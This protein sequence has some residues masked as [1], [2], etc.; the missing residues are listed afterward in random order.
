MSGVIN[1]FGIAGG[2]AWGTAL[3]V[4]LSAKNTNTLLWARE[5]EVVDAIN[6]S[7]ENPDFLPGIP[8]DSTIRATEKLA[9]LGSVEAILLAVPT[10][11]LRK[12]IVELAP[13]ISQ[14]IPLVICSKGIETSSCKLMSE[15][16]SEIL[17]T[18]PISILS[19]PTFAA[20]VARGLPTAVTLASADDIMGA[21]LVEA[22]GSHALRPYLS[23]DVVGA[24]IGGALKNVLAIACGIAVG[25]QLGDNAIAAII[26]RGLAEMLRF[27]HV[28]GAHNETLIGLSGLGD[29][30]LTCN[31]RQSRNISLGMALAKGADPLTYLDG[32]KSVA[33]GAATANAVA[34][35]A[36]IHSI[37]MPI[38]NSIDRIINQGEDIDVIVTELLSRPF[39][40]EFGDSRIQS[41]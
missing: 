5:R 8:L 7:H 40:I 6:D 33:E 2:G 14:S 26:T 25:R 16:I 29:L 9:E 13:Y 17:P 19:G 21:R 34:Q 31:S 30:V 20:E 38:S 12:I 27:G 23:N 18:S 24:Q 41:D 35:V 32:L 37:D 10:Q 39:R 11:H 4:H 22:L 3:A 36:Q 15:I 1:N 28:M